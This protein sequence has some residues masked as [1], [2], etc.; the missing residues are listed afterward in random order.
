MILTLTV[1]LTNT[2]K[3]IELAYS[4]LKNLTDAVEKIQAASSPARPVNIHDDYGQ[5]ATFHAG[6]LAFTMQQHVERQWEYRNERSIVKLRAQNEFHKE[7]SADPAI[8]FL[9]DGVR[10][11]FGSK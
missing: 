6:H 1:T 9:L 10:A 5:V 3:Q 11:E 7:V 2:D 4:S 8:S